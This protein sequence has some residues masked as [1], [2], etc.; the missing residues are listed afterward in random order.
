M[1]FRSDAERSAHYKD[2]H[3][4]FDSSRQTLEAFGRDAG[5]GEKTLRRE[6]ALIDQQ[7]RIIGAAL[8]AAAKSGKPIEVARIAAALTA[9]DM[10][11][12]G[13]RDRED[14]PRVVRA[15]AVD[16]RYIARRWRR[17]LYVSL[18]V[19]TFA[20]AM[21]FM[22]RDGDT[23]NGGPHAPGTNDSHQVADTQS[24]VLGGPP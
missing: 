13:L 18:A 2:L 8:Q 3:G 12:M 6:F 5:L 23:S 20:F 11:A 19:A 7:R 14:V 22:M 4:R 10:T 21:K 1:K 9:D 17:R 15:W 24:Y 16:L